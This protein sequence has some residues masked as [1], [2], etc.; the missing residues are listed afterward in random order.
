MN[1]DYERIKKVATGVDVSLLKHIEAL[2]ARSVNQLAE[3]EKK[4]MRA[5]RKKLEATQAQLQKLKA[6]LFPKENLQE[7]VENV[8]GFYAKWGSGFIDELL[9]HSL[10]LEQ[11]FVVL[12]G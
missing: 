4:M 7:R 10:S 2:K 9:E 12:K 1:L 8:S 6:H 5:E 3:V 11:R